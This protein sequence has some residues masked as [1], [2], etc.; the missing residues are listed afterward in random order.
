M[1]EDG[2]RRL[3]VGEHHSQCRRIIR[4]VSSKGR[5]APFGLVPGVEID[6]RAHAEISMAD[7]R[8]FGFQQF[9]A[10]LAGLAGRESYEIEFFDFRTIITRRILLPK[11]LISTVTAVSSNDWL[12]TFWHLRSA[13][14]DDVPT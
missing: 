6:D 7:R 4:A 13:I 8:R 14:G 12:V 1:L 3:A 2:A 9:L 11:A 5:P 10:R